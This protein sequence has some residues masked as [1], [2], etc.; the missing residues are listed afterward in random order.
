[1]A[2]SGKKTGK[3]STQSVE[4]AILHDNTISPRDDRRL[5]G[6]TLR[7][8]FPRET[9]AGWKA[10]AER[11]NPI[12]ILEKSNEGR[13]EELKPVRY[14][15]MSASPF[16]FF[17]GSAA[18]MAMDLGTVA[19]TGIRVQVCGDCHLL[20]FG[21]FATPERNVL[22]DLNDFDETLPAPWEWDLKR[23]VVSFVLLSRERGFKPKVALEAAEAVTR[24]Y[25]KKIFEFSKMSILDIWY[26]KL[27]WLSVIEK[28]GDPE[29]QKRRKEKLKK[30]KKRTIQ[31]YYFPKMLQEK[32]GSYTFRDNP[33]FLYH[34]PKGEQ[35]VFYM[36]ISEALE[37]YKNS[38][39]EDKQRLIDRYRLT[40]T[41]LK[42][43]GIGSVGTLCGVALMLAPDDEPLLLQIKEA[44]E[45]V[46]EPYAGKSSFDNHGQRVVA[47]QRIIQSAADIFLGWTHFKDG[48]HFYVR[49]LRDMKI[50]PEP[51]IWDESQMV[52]IGKVMGHILARAHARSG[53][54]TMISGYLGEDNVFD[55]AIGSFAVEYADQMEADFEQFTEA[56]KSGKLPCQIDNE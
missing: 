31:D 16:T 24:A 17:R 4:T 52:A 51:D 22:F 33:P 34:R 40:D 10:G 49:Q 25:R 38:L 15:R 18:L 27:D 47:G 3:T 23:L 6:Q 50:K 41:A 43:V 35:E 42:V 32:D 48:R 20:N 28:T 54:A 45:S 30:A 9:H 37:L 21:A 14:G 29:L 8:A 36:Q 1:M 26:A 2:E 11:A 44:R 13:L 39:Q 19:H 53:D 7:E 56:I 46:L 5:R 12:D 55:Q